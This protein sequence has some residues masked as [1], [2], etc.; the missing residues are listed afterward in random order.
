MLAF[1][2]MVILDWTSPLMKCDMHI[3]RQNLI[4]FNTAALAEGENVTHITMPILYASIYL[5]CDL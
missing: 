1:E 4:I 2:I 5:G 3:D